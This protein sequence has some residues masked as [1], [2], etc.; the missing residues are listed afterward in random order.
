MHSSRIRT[1]H[2][3]SHGGLGGFGPDPPEFPPGM[4][5]WISSPRISPC[6]WAWIWHPW[7]CPLGV[8]LDLIPLNFPLGCGPEPD[9]PLGCGPGGG[10]SL[11][12]GSPWQGVS[13]AGVGSPWQGVSWQGGL[14]GRDGL[15]ACTEAEPPRGQTDTCKNIT[16]ANYMA[17]EDGHIDSMF[18]A[19]STRPLDPLLIF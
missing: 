10:V 9:P 2:S 5:A 7:I 14:P 17:A 15:Q 8:G 4:L 3:S 6:V 13:L 16:F 18:L 12:G 11:A 1:A 19:P